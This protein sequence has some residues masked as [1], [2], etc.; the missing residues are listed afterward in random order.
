[1]EQ[2][3]LH[4]LFCLVLSVIL[5]GC[6]GHTRVKGYVYDRDDNPIKDALVTLEYSTH[7]FD[8]LTDKDGAYDVGLVHGPFFASLTLT[9]TKEGFKPFKLPFSS[10][11][12]PSGNYKIVLERIPERSSSEEKCRSLSMSYKLSMLKSDEIRRLRSFNHASNNPSEADES[13]DF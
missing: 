8:A 6:D 3:G 2:K 9:A 13:R 4:I 1:M 7:K 10:N 12:S 5:A 11:S